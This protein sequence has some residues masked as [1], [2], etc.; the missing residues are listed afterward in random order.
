MSRFRPRQV[1]QHFPTQP[2]EVFNVTDAGDGGGS[3]RAGAG[4]RRPLRKGGGA[5]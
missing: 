2:R 1:A 5:G 4:C 3:L